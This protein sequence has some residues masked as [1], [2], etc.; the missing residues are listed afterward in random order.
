[1]LVF[2]HSLPMLKDA[3][4]QQHV[5]RRSDGRDSP[6]YSLCSLRSAASNS[7]TSSSAIF[8]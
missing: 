4:D 2:C 8:L 7:T 6:A 5:F 3:T 1:M